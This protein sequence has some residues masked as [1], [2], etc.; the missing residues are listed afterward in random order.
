MPVCGDMIKKKKRYAYSTIGAQK[1]GRMKEVRE[2]KN[3]VRGVSLKDV[4]VSPTNMVNVDV[5][6]SFV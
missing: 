1:R 6:K 4:R 2:S 5:T 3:D